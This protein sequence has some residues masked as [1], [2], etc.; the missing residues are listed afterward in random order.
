MEE[1]AIK[2]L[3]VKAVNR[4]VTEKDV[5]IGNLNAIKD[6]I[7]EAQISDTE[8]FKDKISETRI[9]GAEHF[10][11]KISEIRITDMK[12]LPIPQASSQDIIELFLDG[13]QKQENLVTEFD[14]DMWYGLVEYATVFGRD[15]VRFTFRDGI[16]LLCRK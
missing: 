3:F 8:H 15:D 12:H 7:F 1:T 5:I 9:A 6:R 2:A 4:I 11:D 16:T 14:E 10:K 13:L